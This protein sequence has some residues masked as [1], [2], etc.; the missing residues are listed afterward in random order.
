MWSTEQ[1]VFRLGV[2]FVLPV[3]QE[4]QEQEQEPHQNLQEESALDF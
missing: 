1:F 3:S 2:S 4:Q